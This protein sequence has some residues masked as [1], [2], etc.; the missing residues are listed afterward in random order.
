VR[1][2][3]VVALGSLLALTPRPA[4]SAA[5]CVARAGAWVPLSARGAPA[6]SVETPVVTIG[7]RVFV[8]GASGAIFDP[9]ANRWSAM[10][11]AGLPD[12]AW[13]ARH[14]GA[15]VVGDR[16]VFVGVG[17][18]GEVPFA[19][20]GVTALVYDVARN[21]WSTVP[22]QPTAF[23]WRRAAMIVATDREVIVWGGVV[24]AN[25]G[26]G[27][28]G[29][30]PPAGPRLDPV[31]GTWRPT[32]RTN[33]PSGR[34]Y[35]RGVW[36]GTRLVVWGGI[37]TQTNPYQCG[38]GGECLPTG[39]GGVYDPATDTWTAMSAAGAPAARRGA[40]VKRVGDAVLVWGGVDHPDGALYD[41]GANTWRP[42]PPSPPAIAGARLDDFAVTVGAGK[43]VVVT[44]RQQAAVYD[45]ASAGWTAVPDAS[46]PVGLKD[47]RDLGGGA[48]Q[49]IVDHRQQGVPGTG[50][51]ARVDAQA[52]RWAF[53][54]LP[55]QN[56][57]TSLES[58][59]VAWNDDQLIVW[60]PRYQQVRYEA[61]RAHAKPC[62]PREPGQPICDPV[63]PVREVRIGRG[64]QEGGL[65]RPVF[66]AAP[67]R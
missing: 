61:D 65:F 10:S 56:A 15:L 36:T 14:S 32:S 51:L 41:P 33:A 29:G 59:I 37:G 2:S 18:N 25:P 63:V 22:D 27:G 43:F 31:A 55:L 62:G 39:G 7:K 44:N 19:T 52:A 35:A 40:A 8:F 54:P 53:A 5:R 34:S 28:G 66:T 16:V 21:R 23:A 3:I 17:N 45:L 48:L 24:E 20:S 46:F 26:R 64:G 12:D 47:L 6:V 1:A 9:C 30:L 13:S 58:G 11:R 49:L 38:M 4:S 57:P 67:S 50:T 60:G 42:L